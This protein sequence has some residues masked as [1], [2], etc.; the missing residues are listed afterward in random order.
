MERNLE[1]ELKWRLDQDGHARLGGHLR[2]SLGESRDL[3]Q[4]NRFFDT[5]D[6]RLR[7][8]RMN[9]RLRWENGDLVLTCK[10]PAP[11]NDAAT[12]L[13]QHDEW[14]TRIDADLWDL[15]EGG[16]A[17]HPRMLP[18]PAPIAAVVAQDPLLPT[19]GFANQRAEFHRGSDLVALDRTDFGARV[20]YELEVET[21]DPTASAAWW[22][23]QLDAWGIAHAPQAHSKFA[24][25]LELK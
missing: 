2:A 24:R 10:R 8:E 22:R 21:P 7:R 4:R 5:A 6:L 16:I 25:M 12:G 19:G 1:V 13:H 23:A 17:L 9:I 20:D 18:L 15:V 3:V 11:G 14:E